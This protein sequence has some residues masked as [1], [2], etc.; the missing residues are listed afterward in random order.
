MR[1][2]RYCVV[3]ILLGA[4]SLPLVAT[5][6]VEWSHIFGSGAFTYV[7]DVLQA[8]DGG[9]IVFGA[10][11]IDPRILQ[12]HLVKLD[13]DGRIEWDR[14]YGEEGSVA[15]SSMLET[16]AGNYLFA[17]TRQGPYG[18]VLS[19][20]MYLVSPTG[21]VLRDWEIGEDWDMTSAY[22]IVLESAAGTQYVVGTV[23]WSNQNGILNYAWAGGSLTIRD[24]P[25]PVLDQGEI[26][27]AVLL[28]DG[29]ILFVGRTGEG[30]QEKGVLSY[31]PPSGG[32]AWTQQVQG[33]GAR[34]AY[35]VTLTTSGDFLVLGASFDGAMHAYLAKF[36]H[37]GQQLWYASY[38]NDVRN[39]GVAVIATDDGGAVVTGNTSDF[40]GP[41][42]VLI[43]RVH[44]NGT[45][46]WSM[47]TGTLLDTGVSINRTQDGG[48]IIGADC[49]PEGY[50][51]AGIRIIKL[52]PDVP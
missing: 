36:S 4:V 14:T 24:F 16:R 42:G 11:E 25:C 17:G 38:G 40:D 28:S 21:D 3:V 35:D 48:Y 19:I 32:C 44:G 8:S 20:A 22:P 45:L 39:L 34:S 41:A 43:F 1:S 52:S 6:T 23:T 9:Y 2:L 27:D 15:P 37:A 31:F 46:V 49:S 50:G 5:P 26:T 30:E 51:C 47:T 18:G 10:M 12:I 7:R 13:A 33:P 29:S